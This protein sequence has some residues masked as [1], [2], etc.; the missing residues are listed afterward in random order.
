MQA[1]GH[2]IDLRVSQEVG[3]DLSRIVREAVANAVRHGAAGKVT[4]TARGAD[5]R[6]N[7]V[8]TDNGR[9]F[10]FQGEVGA[11]DADATGATPRTLTE[12]VRAL[13]GRLELKSSAKG[14]SVIID[15]PLATA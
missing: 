8:I 9:G 5:D 13:G 6:L 3:Y 12:R 11:G 14:A 2:A 7:L 1:D 10:A 15:V 4:V